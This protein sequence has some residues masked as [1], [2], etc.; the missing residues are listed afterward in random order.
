MFARNSFLA[1]LPAL[2]LFL[3]PG[4]L[5]AQQEMSRD[6]D[7]SNRAALDDNALSAAPTAIA[8]EATVVDWDG[9]TLKTGTNDYTCLPDDPNAA[10]NSPRTSRPTPRREVRG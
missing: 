6:D 9:N 1:G 4:G 10:G 3:V 7:D 2:A 5:P 8:A